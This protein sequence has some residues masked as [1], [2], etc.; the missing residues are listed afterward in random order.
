MKKVLFIFFFTICLYAQDN[1]NGNIKYIINASKLPIQTAI[2][3][4]LRGYPI[5][6]NILIEQQVVESK[7]MG[8]YLKNEKNRYLGINTKTKEVTNEVVNSVLVDENEISSPITVP[9]ENSEK[10]NFDKF[11]NCT[12]KTIKD[13][14]ELLSVKYNDYISN[15]E[16]SST[17]KAIE[18]K[19]NFT[20]ALNG[21][22]NSEGIVCGKYLSLLSFPKLGLL[23]EYKSLE[24]INKLSIAE[25]LKYLELTVATFHLDSPAFRNPAI[26]LLRRYNMTKI[27]LKNELS[28]MK[29]SSMQNF[30]QQI[31]KEFE[32]KQEESSVIFNKVAKEQWPEVEKG[33]NWSQSF[34]ERIKN[35]NP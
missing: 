11:K 31:D 3:Y 5:G 13:Y 6:K 12:Q 19:I 28:I 33:L 16:R 23:E 7:N 4:M 15:F 35:E 32:Q 18:Q 20:R 17:I 34:I 9:T 22:K 21:F 10:L 8:E 26:D 30:L 1:Q 27:V 24:V 29:R 14:K 2:Q 25:L